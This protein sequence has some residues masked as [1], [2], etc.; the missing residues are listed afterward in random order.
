M[1]D[2]TVESTSVKTIPRFHKEITLTAGQKL[3][4]DADV[5]AMDQKAVPAGYEIDV[6]V[7][8]KPK[9]VREV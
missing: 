5:L 6:V 9:A 2:F 4:D 7:V 1:A 8:I 3:S